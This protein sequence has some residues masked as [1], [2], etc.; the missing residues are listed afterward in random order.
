MEIDFNMVAGERKRRAETGE[1]DEDLPHA[2]T[3]MDTLEELSTDASVTMLSPIKFMREHQE[4]C[5]YK[6][7]QESS[8]DIKVTECAPKIFKKIRQ[9]FGVSEQEVLEAFSPSSNN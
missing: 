5:I 3:H 6:V 1:D 7:K 9:T 4:R 8:F 2:D